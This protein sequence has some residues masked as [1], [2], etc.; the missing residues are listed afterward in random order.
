MCAHCYKSCLLAKVPHFLCSAGEAPLT[1]LIILN[2]SWALVF[3][4]T[5][6]NARVAFLDRLWSAPSSLF[7]VKPFC[8]QAL[9]SVHCLAKLV[10]WYFCIFYEVL[11]WTCPVLVIL[12]EYNILYM[13]IVN[14]SFPEL[15]CLSELSHRGFNDCLSRLILGRILLYFYTNFVTRLG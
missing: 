7:C 5:S 8:I 13:I 4:K 1:F 10:C 12:S 6:L 15:L 9:S 2:S 14:N 3:L 11:W